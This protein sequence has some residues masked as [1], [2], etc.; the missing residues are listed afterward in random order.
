[1][2]F[3]SLFSQIGGKTTFSLLDFG[4]NARANALGTDFITVKDQDVNLGVIN[5]SVFNKKMNNTGGFNQAFLAGGINLGMI[6]YA[7]NLD[8]ATTLAGHLRYVNYGKMDRTDIAGTVLGSY[9]PTEYILG[10]G[11]GKQL[12]PQISIGANFNMIYSQLESYNSFGIS[13]DIAGSYTLDKANLLVTALV[14]NIGVQINSYT[15]KNRAQLPV[16]FQI[17]ISHKLKHAPFR[18]SIVAHHLNVWDITYN[19]PN[20]KPTIDNLTGDTIAVKYPS[21]IEKLGHHFIFQNEIL[22]SKSIHLRAAFDIH[23]RQELK[24]A[25]RPGMA[26][27][28]FGLGLYFKRISIDYGFQIYSK[29]GYGNMLTLTSN[30]STWK[31]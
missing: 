11:A 18:F 31:K 4:F 2:V 30:L 14:K 21:F 12:N 28:S 29:A 1:M 24:V 26:G 10:I 6:S 13:T 19:D 3:Q 16:D 22:I 25:Q 17:G 5:P 20:L 27:F 23:K 7:K 8:T 15:K 9:N